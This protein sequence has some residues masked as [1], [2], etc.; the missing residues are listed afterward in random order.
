MKRNAKQLFTRLGVISSACLLPISIYASSDSNIQEEIALLKKQN[1]YLMKR[2]KEIAVLKKQNAYLMRKVN[3][4]AVK[5]QHHRNSVVTVQPQPTQS[6]DMKAANYIAVPAPVNFAFNLRNNYPYFYDIIT[7]N[8]PKSYNPRQHCMT[9]G[10]ICISGIANFDLLYTDHAGHT[11]FGIPPGSFHG[12]GVRP[13]FGTSENDI[14]GSINNLD[15]F[16]DGAINDWVS[17]H[18]D[19]AYLN[20]S[21]RAVTYS[22]NSLDLSTAYRAEAGLKVNQAYVLLANPEKIPFFLQVGRY[23][24]PF[25][26]YDPYAI[27]P[28]LTQLIEQSRTGGVMLGAILQNGLYAEAD[29]SMARQ[30]F[31]NVNDVYIGY[32]FLA[33]VFPGGVPVNLNNKDR[34]FGGKIG[35]RGN[36]FNSN[37]HANVNASWIADVRDSDYFQGGWD[38]Y[39]FDFK[40]YPFIDTILRNWFVYMKRAPGAALHGDLTYRWFEIDADYAT[41]LTPL[42][43]QFPN[44]SKIWAWGVDASVSFPLFSMP[45]KFIAGYQRAGDSNIYG[46]LSPFAA[47]PFAPIFPQLFIYGNVLPKNRYLFTY[48]VIV[49]PWVDVALQW[50]HDNDTPRP[51]GS[52]KG[53][54]FIDLRLGFQL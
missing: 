19:L 29:W 10:F 50:V 34:N 17:M 46:A 2:D 8:S 25:G 27:T 16:I 53:S 51:Q 42:N 4:L 48:Q 12:L 39:N 26:E 13:L 43:P 38:N 18:V 22:V 1:A 28:S 33:N 15:L 54:N 3:S 40:Y 32:N 20:G 30:S 41:A 7:T 23:N 49:M 14:F 45:S 9:D 44:N 36:L 52:G 6:Y 35:F 11:Q 37:F 5:G 31:A 47:G 24:A 21:R